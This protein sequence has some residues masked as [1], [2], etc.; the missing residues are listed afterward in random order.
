MYQ[1]TETEDVTSSQTNKLKSGCL[2]K[3]DMRI[4]INPEEEVVFEIDM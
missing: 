2:Q 3:P 1:F 4:K